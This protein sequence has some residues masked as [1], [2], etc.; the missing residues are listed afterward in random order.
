MNLAVQNNI[1]LLAHG[2]VG[3]NSGQPTWALCLESHKVKIQSVDQTG[4]FS[5][6]SQKESVYNS[7]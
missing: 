1:H 5:G 3:Q 2:S 6:D 4:L 7:I